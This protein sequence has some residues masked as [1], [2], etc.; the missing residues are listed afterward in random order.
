M[1]ANK[2]FNT[3]FALYPLTTIEINAFFKETGIQ[4]HPGFQETVNTIQ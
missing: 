4:K 3:S 1:R 2:V